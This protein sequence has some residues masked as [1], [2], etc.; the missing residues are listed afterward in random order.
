MDDT[1]SLATNLLGFVD[2]SD[3]FKNKFNKKVDLVTE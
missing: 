2:M 3:E 1:D